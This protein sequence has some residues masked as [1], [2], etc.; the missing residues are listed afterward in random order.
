[1]FFVT[2]VALFYATLPFYN[3]ILSVCVLE[4]LM[5]DLLG[6][7]QVWIPPPARGSA[8]SAALVELLTALA[9]I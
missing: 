4:H 2:C 1:M 7:M 6:K 9:A 5:S 8:P 3:H